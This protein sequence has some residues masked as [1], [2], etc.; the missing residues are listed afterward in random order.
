MSSD[1]SHTTVPTL[2]K[3]GRVKEPCARFLPKVVAV[4]T[5]AII[6]MPPN[7][8][9]STPLLRRVGH[10]RQVGPGHGDSI[11][12][13]VSRARRSPSAPPRGDLMSTSVSCYGAH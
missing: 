8:G 11:G 7:S 3:L 1:D 5:D 10:M 13:Y 2:T 4:A 12:A 9:P 6:A